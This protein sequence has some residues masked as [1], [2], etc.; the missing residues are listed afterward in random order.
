MVYTQLF[1]FFWCVCVWGGGG[2]LLNPLDPPY[3]RYLLYKTAVIAFLVLVTTAF[4]KERVN[5][6]MRTW[7]LRR[8]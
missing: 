3:L 1:F 6:L 5:V 8:Y 4:V 2:G 7:S